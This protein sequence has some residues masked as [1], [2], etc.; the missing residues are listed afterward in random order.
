M[1]TYP[2]CL[3]PSL[4]FVPHPSG[5]AAPT[6]RDPSE[7][8][9]HT[10][11]STTAKKLDDGSYTSSQCSCGSMYTDFDDSCTS[12][13]LHNHIN[14]PPSNMINWEDD[15]SPL[16]Y[17]EEGIFLH[18]YRHWCFLGTTLTGV[19]DMSHLSGQILE[20]HNFFFRRSANV[21]SKDGET[22]LVGFYHDNDDVRK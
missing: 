10:Q 9:L 13:G 21:K 2:T 20:S 3:T 1:V 4:S 5:S 6:T 17:R 14:F 7:A 18:P 12:K 8:P 19:F 22:Q 15:P 16:Y 11:D